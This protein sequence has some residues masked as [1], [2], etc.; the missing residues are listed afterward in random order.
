MLVL[1]RVERKAFGNARF[2]CR[3][4]CGRHAEMDATNL[5]RGAEPSCGC[6]IKDRP[7]THG[8]SKHPLY[9][10]WYNMLDRCYDQTNKQY[11]DYGGRGV[12]VCDEWRGP[13][14]MAR[15]VADMG[16]CPPAHSIDRI[17]NNQPYSKANCRWAT[18]SQQQRNRR[19][20]RIIE[21]EGRSGTIGD[22][23][24]WL[25]ISINTI[26]YR[27]QVGRPL[28]VVLSQQRFAT[29]G[30]KRLPTDEA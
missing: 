2:M 27:L 5:K 20:T 22:W 30:Q 14:G 8:L 25:G 9:Q 21:Y 23:A 11:L 28:G 13:D 6:A 16:D 29:Y 17:D 19:N 3:C 26:A 7:A 10:C 1:H 12:T 18:R 4:S 24:K 15:F